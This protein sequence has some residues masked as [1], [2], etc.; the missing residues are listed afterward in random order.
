MDVVW[1]YMLIA[2]PVIWNQFEVWSFL[3]Q[4]E[5]QLVM[6]SLFLH[7]SMNGLKMVNSSD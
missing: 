5:I 4:Y 3:F 1:L 6:L 7:D 2:L